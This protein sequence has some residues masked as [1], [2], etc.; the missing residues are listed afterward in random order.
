MSNKVLEKRALVTGGAGFIG[1]HL[2]IELVKQGYT[3]G[4]IDNE[5][6]GTESNLQEAYSL[7]G[8]ENRDRLKYFKSDIKNYRSLKKIMDSLKPQIV[9]HQ[10]AVGSVPR[11]V[12]DPRTT[13]ENNVN[14][15]LELLLACRENG[16]Q[17]VLFA[18]SSSVY[19]DNQTLPKKEEN[20]G[21]PLSQYALSKVVG[22]D[23]MKQFYDLYGLETVTLR[24]FNIF[25][26]RQDPNS[27]YSAVIPK[28]MKSMLSGKAPVIFGDGKQSRDFTYVDNV[29]AANLL[30]AQLPKGQ[31]CG[32]AFNIALG[33]QIYVNELVGVLNNLL[34]TSIKPSYVSERKGEIRHSIADISKARDLGF[35]P[36]IDFEEGLR[37]TLEHYRKS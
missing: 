16:V 20:I 17:R 31:V 28:F 8:S 5:F 14:G 7:S 11:S 9:F 34:G 2:V 30:F 15:T 33:E 10:A 12:E 3:V 37:R 13:M 1:S 21:T 25:G 23:L 26:P 6:N 22:D 29:V 27:D 24:Y 18:S 4:V 32:K 35:N 36:K 19:G